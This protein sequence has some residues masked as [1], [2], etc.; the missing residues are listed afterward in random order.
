M[1]IINK[2]EVDIRS[3]SI[4]AW[5]RL[6]TS[7][8]SKLGGRYASALGIN[9]ASM[10]ADEIFKW[11]LASIL[12]GARISEAVAIR[13]Y[14]EFKQAGV[15][16]PEA[17]LDTGWDG[18]VSILDRGGYARYDFRTATKLL[19]V[20]GTLR[21]K[22]AG[23]LNRL[24][25]FAQDE[26]DLEKKLKR[27]GKGIG[28]VTVR[29]FLRELRNIWEKAEP[30]LSDAALFASRMLGLTR[31]T[32]AALA[33]EEM[34]EMWEE[35]EPARAGFPDLEAALV[36]L[37]KNFCL[38]NKCRLCVVKRECQSSNCRKEL[39]EIAGSL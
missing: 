23:D 17:V 9:L 1:S 12:F 19:D 36:K 20:T 32:D 30:P 39:S 18:L 37:G 33:L 28:P 14:G 13:T 8:T 4:N 7:L 27:L 21:E 34:R 26:R 15:L 22:Y 2:T 35:S 31:T 10:E 5:A 38:K 6:C 3:F 24:H 16:C 29:I 11:F 25:F